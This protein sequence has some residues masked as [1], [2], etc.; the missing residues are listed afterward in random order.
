M[1]SW[2]HLPVADNFDGNREN[3]L[4]NAIK[5]VYGE[6]RPQQQASSDG[7]RV[8]MTHILQDPHVTLWARQFDGQQST[9]QE[10]KNALRYQLNTLKR[11]DSDRAQHEVFCQHAYLG[12]TIGQ[13]SHC[14]DLFNVTINGNG[15]GTPCMEQF[16]DDVGKPLLAS[17]HYLF[18]RMNDRVNPLSDD[19]KDQVWNLLK[20]HT[21][22]CADN[23]ALGMEE[24]HAI[25][26]CLKMEGQA[27]YEKAL[28]S[29]MLYNFKRSLIHK[30]PDM[31][32]QEGVL[33]DLGED[34]YQA[35]VIRAMQGDL[36][37]IEVFCDRGSASDIKDALP[38]VGT[39]SP[40]PQQQILTQIVNGMDYGQKSALLAALYA[41]SIESVEIGLN[42]SRLVNRVLSTGAAVSRQN[43]CHGLF[44]NITPSLVARTLCMDDETALT[45]F[46][47]SHNT[48]QSHMQAVKKDLQEAYT[49]MNSGVS[50][51]GVMGAFTNYDPHTDGTMNDNV[52]DLIRS[53]VQ[54]GG[55]DRDLLDRLN[56]FDNEFTRKALINAGY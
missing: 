49:F 47:T 3:A 55:S 52:K 45:A 13:R 15:M 42:V 46:F 29:L 8:H 23:A 12:G 31:G 11:N 17:L 50:Y 14:L 20:D 4:K 22:T 21:T 2:S 28:V 34:N 26:L 48:W 33:M 40:L 44:N 41:G 25:S 1:Q 37:A 9:L 53:T 7:Y 24:L 36:R 51:N 6:R 39:G 27:D 18:Q 30:M 43:Y 16:T 56:V 5:R 54:A 38:G 32:Y 10:L 19:L 35:A